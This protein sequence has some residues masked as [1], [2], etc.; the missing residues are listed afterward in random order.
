M[1]NKEEQMC[2]SL[3]LDFSSVMERVI[4]WWN[5]KAISNCVLYL[6]IENNIMLGNE[7]EQM[8]TRFFFFG[9]L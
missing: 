3:F 6:F 2:T 7:E 1:K 9:F 8:C 4:F 5:L